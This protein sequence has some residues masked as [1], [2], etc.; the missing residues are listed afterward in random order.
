MSR[1]RKRAAWILGGVAVALL[2][3]AITVVVV[4]RSQWFY[5]RVRH[6]IIET[7]ET[8]TGGRVEIASFQFNWHNLRAEVRAFTLHG[9]E[10][11]D[12][13]PLLRAESVVVGLKL[14]SV[15]KRQVDIAYLDVI[16]PQVYLIVRPDGSTNMPEPKIAKKAGK[17]AVQTILDLAIGRFSLERGQFEIASHGATPFSA[18]GTNLA[19]RFL[20]DRSGPRYRGDLSIQPLHLQLG[21]YR[22]LPVGI[23]TSLTIEANRLEVSSAKVTSGASNIALSGALENLTSSPHGEF[24]FDASVAVEEVT[25]ILRIPELRR[26]KVELRG[27]ATWRGPSDFFVAST[28]HGTGLA[29]RDPSV[30]LE[31]F[32][33]DGAVTASPAGLDANGLRLNGN[34]VTDLG[35][36]PVDAIIQTAA[37]RGKDLQLRGM[38]LAVYGGHFQGDAKVLN[39][40]RYSAVG[41]VTD[42]ELRPVVAMYDP[43]HLPWNALAAGPIAVEGSFADSSAVRAHATLAISPAS[44][45]PPVHG[46]IDASYQAIDR[47]VDLGRST[48]TLP[49]SQVD[50][51]GT[52][53]RQLH[54]HLTTRDLDDLLPAL[55][56]KAANLPA[57]LTG[58]VNFDGTVSGTI[59]N[60]QIAGHTRITG[61]V[62]QGENF[63]SLE[64]DANVSPAGVRMRNGVVAQGQMRTQFQISLGMNDWKWTD[65]SPLSG[66]GTLHGGTVDALVQV[67][68]LK[69]I[70]IVA[71]AA[72]SAQIS[73]TIG[74]PHVS[75]DFQLTQGAVFNEP[76]DRF[77]GHLNFNAGFI[78]VTAGQLN[79]GNGQASLTAAYRHAIGHFDTGHLQL[80]VRTNARLLEQIRTIQ[81]EY[82]GL[83]GTVTI[84]GDGEADVLPARSGS[85]I[86]QF[87][88]TALDADVSSRALQLS[89]QALGETHL[90][91][92]SQG[93]VLRAHLDSTAASS[94]VRGDGV[95]RLEGN[96]PGDAT[97]TFSKLD[98]AKLR[99]WLEPGAVA[100]PS[101]F[102]GSAEGQL[103]IQGPLLDPQ[104]LKAQLTIPQF[105]FGPPPDSDIPAA[106]LTLH[107]AGPI[108]ASMEN[109]VITV[110]SARLTGAATDFSITGKIALQQKN[111]LELH[112]VGH[113]DLALVHDFNRDFTSAGSVSVD[114][115][116]RGP[117]DSPQINGRT[118]F[119]KASFSIEGVPN[120]ISNANGVLVFVDDKANGTRATIQSFSGETGGGKIELT[121]F[122][123]YNSGQTIFRVHA[124][125]TEVRI[126]YPEGVSTVVNGGLNL[127]GTDDRSN[128]EG[129]ITI[130][131]TGFNPQSDFSSLLGRSAQP[132]ETP[133]AR[134][135]LL[136]GLNFDIQINTAPDVQFQ[137][138]LTQDVQME[139]NLRLRG[140]FSNPAV[141]GR[142][143]FSQGRVIFFGTKYTITQGS[144]QFFNPVRIDPILDIDLETRINGIDVTLTV[145]GPF[146]KLNLTPRSDPPLQLNEIIALLATG[147]SPTSDP[148]RLAQESTSPQS[149]QQM[150]ASALLGQ[151]LTS[152]VSGRL[153]RFFGVSQL[154]IDPSLPGVENN[155]QAR[156]ILQQQVTNDITFTYI[157]DLNNS[158][159]EV[160]RVEWSFAKQWS[161]VALREDNGLFGIDFF[162]KKRF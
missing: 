142:I 19:T 88:I 20:Y 63:D 120:G 85:D 23:A 83:K 111:P 96:Y 75:S 8:A 135:G 3:F 76:F 59:D 72:G 101:P 103:T 43:G 82:P 107:N 154:R 21:S 10:P 49:S 16:A 4:I 68:D 126:R 73:G 69:N 11:A 109:K 29:Y 162:F 56:E 35:T 122:A 104:A 25:P 136:G 53:G 105:E 144:V 80:H 131:R 66:S 28:L 117:L 77:T 54:V 42:I 32:R 137:S 116:A 22:P 155:P 18:R 74:D 52:L 127:T 90:T 160:L 143:T 62:F 55:G 150:G 114:V 50:F 149:W 148:T 141:L 145:S 139:A 47:T 140:T 26:G 79:A 161:V 152:P 58:A 102:T 100:T 86:P 37:L 128:L 5:N 93:N 61:I 129:T 34:Y 38:S 158:N 48:I 64:G 130:V 15:L 9:T 94:Q 81:K 33:A 39:L 106:K 147:R 138:E 134:T 113:V 108:V 110:D 45:S 57:K 27:N 95:W 92:S 41:A 153:Q 24:K 115:T 123:G 30:R 119:Q 31:G 17:P 60:P 1:G 87:R 121:G 132:V 159:P 13:P 97:V 6:S 124:S 125:A 67:L 112:G 151:A 89:D 71:G 12:K 133:A 78:E 14:V 51:S 70:P 44:D 91:V 2:A 98:L 40:V 156:L 157:A 99:T 36:A 7:V 118:E 46:E 84:T 65:A 146:T